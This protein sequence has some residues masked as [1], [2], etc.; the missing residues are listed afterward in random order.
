MPRTITQSEWASRRQIIDLQAAIDAAISSV[1][2]VTYQ[3]VMVALSRVADR[4][5]TADWQSEFAAP[6]GPQEMVEE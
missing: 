6:I 3:E 5:A 2:G 4:F 1:P